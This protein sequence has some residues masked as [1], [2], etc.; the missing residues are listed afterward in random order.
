[1]TGEQV[2]VALVG[3]GGSCERLATRLAEQGIPSRVVRDAALARAVLAHAPVEPA[4]APR[5]QLL[6][7]GRLEIDTARRQAR[8]DGTVLALRRREFDLLAW[9]AREPSRVFTRD[10]LLAGVWGHGPLPRSR[11]LDTHASRL[12]RVL[13]GR[14]VRMVVNVWGVGYALAPGGIEPPRDC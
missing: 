10:E 14:G 2:V 5:G 12:R 13:A 1:V 9:L 3:D 8:V 11:T 4:P 6:C 7:A